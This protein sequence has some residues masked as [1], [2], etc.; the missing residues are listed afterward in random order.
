MPRP[1]LL[2]VEYD[3][4]RMAVVLPGSNPAGY[5]LGK[6]PFLPGGVFVFKYFD[7]WDTGRNTRQN[8]LDVLQHEPVQRYQPIE[9][10]QATPAEDLLTT[11]HLQALQ[12]WVQHQPQPAWP[13][14]PMNQRH[15]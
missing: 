9:H 3:G 15:R 10:L 2:G 7:F 14:T 8:L 4:Q 11:A 6:L 5:A 13:F 12:R 1:L